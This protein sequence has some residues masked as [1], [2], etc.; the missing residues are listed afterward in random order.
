MKAPGHLRQLQVRK[1]GELLIFLADELA[2]SRRKAKDLLDQRLVFVN[3]QRVWMAKHRL[4]H[5][6]RVEIL[7]ASSESRPNRPIPLLYHANGL[8]VADKPAGI[9]STGPDGLEG[10]L[11]KQLGIP[12]LKAVHR[13]DADTTGC[14]IVAHSQAGFDAMVEVFR[15]GKIRKTYRALVAAGASAIPSTINRPLDGKEAVTHCRILG[16]TSLAHHVEVVIETGRTH[17]IRRHLAEAGHPVL[18]DKQYFTRRVEAPGLRRIPR[19]MLHAYQ[20]DFV[21]PD[22]GSVKA[23]APLPQDFIKAL[24]ALGL[25]RSASD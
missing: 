16:S 9:E 20:L 24:S 15:A 1:P 4:Q 13:L 17:Q 3:R 8:L 2:L 19:Q 18:G 23:K 25:R 10:T 7:A 5:G 21:R 6:D 22:G 11:R 12:E 14:L